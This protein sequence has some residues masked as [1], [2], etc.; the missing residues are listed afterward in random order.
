MD[1]QVG[2]VPNQVGSK[3][4]IEKREDN[5]K[6]HLILVHRMQISIASSCQRSNSLVNRHHVSSPYAEMKDIFHGCSNPYSFYI[7]IVCN[8]M[9]RE[10]PNTMHCEKCYLKWNQPNQMLNAKLIT[11]AITSMDPTLSWG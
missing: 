11:T 6:D 1:H 9:I 8:N 2:H 4:K 3:S 7:T 5:A 10:T